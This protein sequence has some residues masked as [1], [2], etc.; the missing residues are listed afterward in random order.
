MTRFTRTT[1]CAASI[2]A[3]GLAATAQADTL[4]TLQFD[5]NVLAGQATGPAPFSQSFTGNLVIS[6]QTSPLSMLGVEINSVEQPFGAGFAFSA[7][8]ASLNFVGGFVTDGSLMLEVTDGTTTNSFTTLMETA[9]N[10]NGDIAFVRNPTSP[11]GSFA[12]FATTLNGAFDDSSFGGIDVSKFFGFQGQGDNL[13]GS[14]IQFLFSPDA[15]G[16]DGGTNVD[17][18]ISVIPLPAPV[19]MGLAGLA[20][21]VVIRRRRIA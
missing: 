9:G 10:P 12:I 13:S 8:Q 5:A 2:A 18:I 19:W 16:F 3:I 15:N 4:H 14:F 1:L 11:F 7:F 17:V 20:G 6:Y 21:I